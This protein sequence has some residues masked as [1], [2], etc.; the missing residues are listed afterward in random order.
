VEKIKKSMFLIGKI[1]NDLKESRI[2]WTIAALF[3]PVPFLTYLFHEFGHW[4]VEESLGNDM[5]L[6][7]NNST[8]RSGHYIDGTLNLYISM[9]GPA[10]NT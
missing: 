5:V 1:K 8:A 10:F 3:V 4:I 6:S 9:G 7:L 2:N